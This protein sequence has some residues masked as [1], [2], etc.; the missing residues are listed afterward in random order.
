VIAPHFHGVPKLGNKFILW[1][2]LT[3]DPPHSDVWNLSEAEAEHCVGLIW[4]DNRFRGPHA[5]AGY[6]GYPFQKSASIK[7]LPVPFLRFF[8]DWQE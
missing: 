6:L 4:L 8:K 2:Y 7:A 1:P 5:C 3:G